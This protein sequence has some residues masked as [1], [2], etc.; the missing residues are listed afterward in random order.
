MRHLSRTPDTLTVAE[1]KALL[2][3]TGRGDGDLRDHIIFSI[4]LGTGLR[5]SEI[6]ALN[7]ADVANG[8]GAKGVWTLR[9]ETT[10]GG[11]GG[12]VALPDRLRR[13]VS[14]FLTWKV[15]QGELVTPD[16]PLLTCRGGGPDGKVCGGRLAPFRRPC[17]R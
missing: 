11:R 10:K 1:S 3:A 17:G 7:I 12:T 5:V 16:A 6:S 4:A 14:R 8:R 2:E 15:A 13:K 9:P